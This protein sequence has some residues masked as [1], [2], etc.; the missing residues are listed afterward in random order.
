MTARPTALAAPVLLG[1]LAL[2]ACGGEDARGPAADTPPSSTAAALPPGTPVSVGGL[3]F[4]VPGDWH[5]RQPGDPALEGFGPG[6]D[7]VVVGPDDSG[8]QYEEEVTVDADA[9]A[10]EAESLFETGIAL[11]DAD[12]TRGRPTPLGP[13]DL[14]SAPFP[15]GPLDL[16]IGV[17]HLD[18]GDGT[19]V[20]ITVVT[21]DEARTRA[22]LDLAADT[23]DRAP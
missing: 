1:L 6:I 3:A 13:A 5:V 23:L 8:G 15:V 16:T 21:A 22:V 14:G 19:A 7:L 9:D 2:T 12:V 17:L 4:E 10:A 18:R 20:T 11:P